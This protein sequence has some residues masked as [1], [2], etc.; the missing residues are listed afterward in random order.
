MRFLGVDFGSRRT[1]LAISDELGLFAHSLKCIVSS[2]IAFTARKVA[3]VAQTEEVC[4]IVVGMPK[5]MNNSCGER[6]RLT[7]KF[8]ELLSDFIELPLVPFDERL[9]TAVALRD[10]HACGT[11]REKRKNIIDSVSATVLLQDY[12]DFLRNT[13]L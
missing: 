12:L 9:T 11:K 13:K 1:G 7:L 5:N 6:V 4:R 8:M 2:D 10:L 3:S